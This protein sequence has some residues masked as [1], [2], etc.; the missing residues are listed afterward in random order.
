MVA[1]GQVGSAIFEQ[2]RTQPLAAPDKRKKVPVSSA[3]PVAD[4]IA[5]NL[6]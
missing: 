4:L 1:A 2:S 6:I 3:S 5:N